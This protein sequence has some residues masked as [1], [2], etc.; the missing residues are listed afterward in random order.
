MSIADK[1]TIITENQQKVS[2]AI[3]EIIKKQEELMEYQNELINKFPPL[4]TV[5]SCSP[6]GWVDSSA[7]MGQIM[8]DAYNIED[9]YVVKTPTKPEDFKTC[10]GNVGD[11]LIIH[12][13]ADSTCLAD[14]NDNT[15]GSGSIIM[16]ISDFES[17]EQNN[18]IN[19]VFLGG[20]QAAAGDPN[21]N[22]AYWFSK[23]IN[24]QGVVIANTDF[25]VGAVSSTDGAT[26][27]TNQEPTWKL[28]KNGDIVDGAI[29]E[30]TLTLKLAY[31]YYFKYRG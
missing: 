21:N 31:D 17:L 24:S 6:K 28:Y 2:K 27:G 8:S 7:S 16:K 10:W 14:H 4:I 29:S 20:C 19:F 3:E 11:C 26:W 30:V 15:G 9:D 5:I 25:L 1:L 23:K 22:I 12:T 18:N 13:H